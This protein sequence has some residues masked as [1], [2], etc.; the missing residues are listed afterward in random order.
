MGSPFRS[1]LLT[2]NIGASPT[3]AIVASRKT[4]ASDVF[5][6]VLLLLSL[7]RHDHRS[8]VARVV[9]VAQEDV[10]PDRQGELAIADG[11]DLEVIDPDEESGS[12]E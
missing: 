2:C 4:G 6:E 3:R 7:N 5:K 9:E 11:D 1:R 10:L 8:A 12:L